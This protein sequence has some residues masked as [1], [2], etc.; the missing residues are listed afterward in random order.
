M[1][2]STFAYG[3]CNYED[4]EY[5]DQIFNS[6]ETIFKVLKYPNINIYK[7]AKKR[8]FHNMHPIFEVLFLK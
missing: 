3:S 7:C 5:H 2:K 4:Y 1:L 6:I 8:I